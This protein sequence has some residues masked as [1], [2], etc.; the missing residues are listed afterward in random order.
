[1]TQCDHAVI[2]NSSFAWWGAWLG[3]H[4]H[5]STDR[6]VVAP[7]EYVGGDRVPDRWHTVPAGVHLDVA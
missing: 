2:A 7:A 5:P 1:M 3:E 4:R 6:V